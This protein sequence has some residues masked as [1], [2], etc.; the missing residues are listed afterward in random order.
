MAFAMNNLY[1]NKNNK[2]VSDAK[3]VDWIG[4]VHVFITG[5]TSH[6]I[7]F[8]HALRRVTGQDF[9]IQPSSI[10]E[11]YIIE[12][13]RLDG[14][15]PNGTWIIVQLRGKRLISS[16]IISTLCLDIPKILLKYDEPR[17]KIFAC[18]RRFL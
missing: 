13:K 6:L 16:K 8:G 7:Q 5:L 15:S 11:E 1:T 4:N 9:V 14:E 3:F 17:N 12:E 10:E 18:L 2:H